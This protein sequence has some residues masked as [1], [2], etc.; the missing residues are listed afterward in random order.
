MKIDKVKVC[1]KGVDTLKNVA[2]NIGMVCK[3]C[4]NLTITYNDDTA[5]CFTI[6]KN[7]DPRTDFCQEFSFSDD[8][9]CSE[10]WDKIMEKM[11][12]DPPEIWG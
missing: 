2:R 7:V 1:M 8:N 6:D 10:L 3:N 5:Y 4:E 12:N 11:K 9:A